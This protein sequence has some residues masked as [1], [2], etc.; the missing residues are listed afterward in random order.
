MSL[1]ALGNYIDTLADVLKLETDDMFAQQLAFGGFEQI[2]ALFTLNRLGLNASGNAVVFVF[3]GIIIVAVQGGLIGRWSRKYG[4][5][6]LIF[7]GL[8]LLFIGLILVGLTPKEPVPW[9]SR[10]EL[11]EELSAEDGADQLTGQAIAVEIPDD[12]ET[13]WLGIGWILV[14]MIP[15][16]IGGGILHPAINSLITK[17]SAPNEV[18]AML[19]VSAAFFSGA[20]AIAPLIGGA[21]F[22]VFGSTSPFIVWGMT[23]GILLIVALRFVQPG[24]EEVALKAG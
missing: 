18:G 15:V 6:K 8:A 2:L 10:A 4:D 9:Y 14:V 19:G 11:Q 1:A 5:R 20:N 13:G 21:L 12:D 22:Q 23:M 16:A 17:R 24:R 7:S 3:V